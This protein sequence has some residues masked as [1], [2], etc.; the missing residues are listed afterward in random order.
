VRERISSRPPHCRLLCGRFILPVCAFSGSSLPFLG[1]QR[2]LTAETP[3]ITSQA[4]V[5]ANHAMAGNDNGNGICSARASHGPDSGRLAERPGDLTVGARL[6]V[7]NGLQFLPDPALKRGSLH[8]D[9]KIDMGLAALEMRKHV[10]DEAGHGAM[11]PADLGLRV[12]LGQKG[13]QRFASAAEAQR[14]DAALGPG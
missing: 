3:A 13:L 10:L 14:A 12:F 5:L 9:R 2:P 6:A 11:M 8:I 7:R 1:E 4:A